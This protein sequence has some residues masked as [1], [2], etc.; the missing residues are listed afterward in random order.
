MAY[1]TIP[2]L[3]PIITIAI[4]YFYW[5]YQINRELRDYGRSKSTDRFGSQRSQVRSAIAVAL[6]WPIRP[7]SLA[8]CA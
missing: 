4:Y 8:V 6:I 3:L 5:W 2:L 7:T 1:V